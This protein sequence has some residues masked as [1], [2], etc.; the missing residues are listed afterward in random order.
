MRTHTSGRTLG[1]FVRGILL[2]SLLSV[3]PGAGAAVLEITT[4]DTARPV[5]VDDRYVGLAPLV[6]PDLA[7]G[8]H[9]IAWGARPAEVAWVR[10]YRSQVTLAD[11]ET[12]RVEAPPLQLLRIVSSGRPVDLAID[13]LP[14]GRTP[15]HLLVPADR[16]LEMRMGAGEPWLYRALAGPESTLV[17]AAPAEARRA[18]EALG[19]GRGGLLLPLG[20]VVFGVVGAWARQEGDRAYDDYLATVDRERMDDLFDRAGRYDDVAVG[21]WVAAEALLALSVWTWLR[22]NGVEVDGGTPLTLDGAGNELRLG[23]TL[24]LRAA[25]EPR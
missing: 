10:P 14:V 17:V 9:A 2:C 5:W 21:C 18:P 11:D 15:L 25:E 24:P 4:A 22:G 23:L 13:A 3:P 6:V 12:R 7:A 19:R 20:A 16:A 1:L 8:S